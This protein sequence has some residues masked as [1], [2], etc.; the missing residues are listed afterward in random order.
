M[1][2]VD[3]PSMFEAIS[4][5]LWVEKAPFLS[6]MKY[7]L[8]IIDRWST[9]GVQEKY[10]MWEKQTLVQNCTLECQQTIKKL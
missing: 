7:G 3:K 1:T 9:P 2:H 6:D 8:G 5:K 10:T 4:Y